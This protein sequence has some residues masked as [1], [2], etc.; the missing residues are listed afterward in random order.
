MLKKSK[1]AEISAASPIRPNDETF[2]SETLK[3]L[4]ILVVDDEPINRQILQRMLS[5]L[6]ALIE[7]A[8]DGVGALQ[9]CRKNPCD[10]I[11]MDVQMPNMDGLEATRRIRKLPGFSQ[12][13]ILAITANTFIEDRSRCLE[14]GMN[15]FVA[16]PFKRDFLLNTVAQWVHRKTSEGTE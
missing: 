9:Y 13:P 6:G 3:D 4:H 1:G 2:S 16:K 5:N 8:E 11:L 10:L 14:A 7:C 15:D 12:T